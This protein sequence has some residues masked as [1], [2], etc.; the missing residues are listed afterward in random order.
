M[1]K[2]AALQRNNV[3]VFGSGDKTLMFAH[4][5]GCDQTMWRFVTDNMQQDFTIVTFDYVGSG[6][7]DLTAFT[8][9]RYATLDGY[10]QDISDILEALDLKD[11]ALI[12]H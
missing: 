1:N 8:S 12:G 5:F 6:Q 10:A 7:S 2:N 9:D 3:K 4:G 11:V